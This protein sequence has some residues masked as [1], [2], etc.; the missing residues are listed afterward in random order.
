MSARQ[1]REIRL[2]QRPVGMPSEETFELAVS[3]IPPIADGEFLV[4]NIWMS[5]DPYMRGRMME[6]RSYV[7]PFEIGQPL[8][9]G[10][11]GQVVESK[12]PRFA[13]GSYVLGMNGWREYWVSDG[14]G[15]GKIDPKLAPIQA[16]L[17]VLGMP[18]LT[19]YVGLI[20]IGAVAEGETVFV[21]GAAGAVGSVV[22]QIAKAKGCRVVGSAGSQQKV[23]WLLSEAGVDHAFNYQKVPDLAA[24]LAHACSDG[25]DI[26]FE[27]VG[28]P[29]LDAALV[30]MR[31]F[32]R[33]VVCGLISQYN[34]TSPEPG[35]SAFG[36]VIPRRLRIQ[37]FIVTD[38]ADMRDQFLKDMAQWIA[39]SKIKWRETVVEGIENAPHAFLGLFHG[40]NL[41]K[42][43]VKV[44]PDP[45][46]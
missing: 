45:A 23:D 35:P 6:R 33:I 27:N 16:Y 12:N 26:Y 43:L 39:M 19:A 30:N 25:I 5:V 4:R 15:V 29:Q 11:V 28:G 44:G 8:S 36:L 38:H 3:E 18:G 9:G 21:S 1:N 46:I 41:G 42:M 22:C 24:E 17:G 40:D 14:R 37:G 7:A 10:S 20:K 31:D 32:G 13:V 34:A 2:R